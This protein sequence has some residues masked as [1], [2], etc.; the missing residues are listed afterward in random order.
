MVGASAAPGK[1]RGYK[2]KAIA[3][4]H[5]TWLFRLPAFSVAT[6]KQ[7]ILTAWSPL[8]QYSRQ[9]R[10]TPTMRALYRSPSSPRERAA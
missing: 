3:G 5:R 6:S 2:P 8:N 10:Y 4:E 1:I 7:M 9:R